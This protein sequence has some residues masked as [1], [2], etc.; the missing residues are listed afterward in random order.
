[1]F[2]EA[3]RQ[4]EQPGDAEY[5]QKLQEQERIRQ[6]DLE[7]K[8]RQEEADAEMARKMQEWVNGGGGGDMPVIDVLDDE[9]IARQYEEEDKKRDLDASKSRNKA[10]PGE[11]KKGKRAL[12]EGG[13]ASGTRGKDKVSSEVSSPSRGRVEGKGVPSKGR[14]DGLGTGIK[15]RLPSS[16]PGKV[17]GSVAGSRGGSSSK[18]CSSSKGEEHLSVKGKGR[19]EDGKAKIKEKKGKS[20]VETSEESDED[21]SDYDPDEDD[22]DSDWDDKKRRRTSHS[23]SP[24]K[25]ACVSPGGEAASVVGGG[26]ASSSSGSSARPPIK[27]IPCKNKPPSGHA[28]SADK[29]PEFPRIIKRKVQGESAPGGSSSSSSSSSSSAGGKSS[30]GGSSQVTVNKAGAGGIAEAVAKREDAKQKGGKEEVGKAKDG[31]GTGK[32]VSAAKQEG[33]RSQEERDKDEELRIL[34]AQVAELEVELN[35]AKN[36]RSG[37]ESSVLGDAGGGGSKEKTSKDRGQGMEPSNAHEDDHRAD[38]QPPPPHSPF[39]SSSSSSESTGIPDLVPANSLPKQN[40]SSSSS[41]SSHVK[42]NI[43][44][45][46]QPNISKKLQPNLGKKP[47]AV[48]KASHLHLP[49]KKH[50]KGSCKEGVRIVL[51]SDDPDSDASDDNTSRQAPAAPGN[52]VIDLD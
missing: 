27:V 16:P 45:K 1:M 47:N 24:S 50:E 42:T 13:E 9:Q 5:A 28:G 14:V 39:S 26:A 31:G 51:T 23:R 19:V 33:A 35:K 8:A 17:K 18:G 49:L 3:V 40:R 2:N 43:A 10:K 15:G 32:A 29:H 36:P 38:K 21:D 12:V 20:R 37:K 22:D 4:G 48:K 41:S 7:S 46:S 30:G 6:Q 52:I 44:K 11:D 25:K 34:K